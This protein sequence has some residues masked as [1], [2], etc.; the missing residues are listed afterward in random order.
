ML[1]PR[2]RWPLLIYEI[3]I[4][5]VSRLEVNISTYL[6]KWLNIHCSTTNICLY[7]S[8]SPCP[9]P[10]KSLTSVLKSAKVSGHLLLRDSSDDQISKSDYRLKCG[11]WDVTEAVVDAESKLEFQKII[12]YH[13]T[14]KAGFGLFKQP[15]IPPRN[16]YEYRSLISD[17]VN[18][19]DE[20]KYQAKSVQLHMQGYWTRWCN[21]VK[22]DLSW[23][24]LL[25]MP[26][27]L[28][29][30]C[31]G[32]T[33]DTL[34]SP[35]N[36]KRW[37]IITEPSCYLCGKSICTVAHILGA[38]RL[39]LSQG[40]YTYRHDKVLREFIKAIKSFLSSYKPS[41]SSTLKFIKFVKEGQKSK[42]RKGFSGILHSAADWNLRFDLDEPLVIPSFLS[43]SSL[44]PDILLF[45]CSTRMVIIIELTCPCEENMSQWHEEKSQKYHSLCTSIRS[46]NW[47]VYF[48]AIE[49]GARGFCAESVR[50][51]LRG[52]GFSTKLSRNTLKALS[53]VSLKCSFEIW[54]C[55]NSKSWSLDHPVTLEH[56]GQFVKSRNTVKREK[57]KVKTLD[58]VTSSSSPT[59]SSKPCGLIYKGNTCYV[60]VFLQCL[61]SIPALWSSSTSVSSNFSSSIQK[62]LFL[63]H[64]S[65]SPIDPS[66]FLLCLKNTFNKIGRSSFD[67]FAQQDV[68]EVLEVILEELS[69]SSLFANEVYNI[70]G[71]T[72]IMCHTC[73]QFTK[74]EDNITILRLPV[75]KDFPTSLRKIL[76]IESLTGPNSPYC[77]VCSSKTESD[78]KFSLTSLG[79]CLIVQLKRFLVSDGVVS[80][81]GAP[82][83]LSDCVD[84]VTELEDE[85]F[86]KRRFQLCAVINHSGNMERGHY[87]C[88]V[89]VG[90]LWWHCN[91][92]A[93]VSSNI[94]DI[95]A[96]L[97]YIL[98]YQVV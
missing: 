51:C 16:T 30:F 48:F 8:S 23:K 55:R 54:L 81:Y 58:A 36:L 49:V 91:D 98:F 27:S 43:V 5:V 70:K 62:I 77:N 45:S 69:G 18:E 39:A 52:L 28:I 90:D 75:V 61:K 9:L 85:V 46:N 96:S 38:C 2:L 13:Q 76:E 32:A 20:N 17:L 84:V 21:F 19:D 40:R 73:N 56:T 6:R 64:S 83:L 87:T 79:S 93:V 11:F 57:P 1:I 12:G 25:A 94:N 31:L 65:K 15:T 53:S 7:S 72:S 60:N 4:S 89:K 68:A 34:P 71:L 35:S 92:K 10:L 44:R 80:K 29:T 22:N 47:S 78:S 97:P 42:S 67:I 33:F 66:F 14:S 41:K 50:S 24:T 74:S 59:I 95:H 86:C 26:S 88:L 37:K 3:S 63:L 82:F